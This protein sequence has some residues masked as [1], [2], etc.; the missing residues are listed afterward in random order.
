MSNF[1][2][3]M[4][5]GV[6]RMGR[7]AERQ[8]RLQA[9]TSVER[10]SDARSSN[11]PQK[12]ERSIDGTPQRGRRLGE[13]RFESTVISRRCNYTL[14]L[15]AWVKAFFTARSPS[16]ST[17]LFGS[18]VD[19]AGS[20]YAF[21]EYGFPNELAGKVEANIGQVVGGVLHIKIDVQF[22]RKGTKEQAK[23]AETI[24]DPKTV[25]GAKSEARNQSAR[26][27]KI[28][29]PHTPMPALGQLRGSSTEWTT[30][31][32]TIRCPDLWGAHM[33]IIVGLKALLLSGKDV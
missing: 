30:R 9:W 27:P 18:R 22:E 11:E 12:L 25:I 8:G 28:V 29:L 13:R 24:S 19:L 23:E 3:R 14:T 10:S 21:S 32:V 31:G 6:G 4:T 33:D 26:L 2:H 20:A 1:E 17:R 5:Y 15:C 7:I 16:L